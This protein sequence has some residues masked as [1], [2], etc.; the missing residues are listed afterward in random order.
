MRH[1]LCLRTRH[2]QFCAAVLPCLSNGFDASYFSHFTELSCNNRLGPGGDYDLAR[3]DMLSMLL[4][5]KRVLL[6]RIWHPSKNPTEIKP[7]DK[8][9]LRTRSF[10]RMSNQ[11]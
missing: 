4:L 1:Y 8:L 7:F 10:A 3:S 9:L 11:Q 2:I 6:V 5:G